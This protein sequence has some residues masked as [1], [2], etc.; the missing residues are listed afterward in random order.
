M[1]AD[2][3]E[4]AFARLMQLGLERMPAI[5]LFRRCQSNLEKALA[6]AEHEAPTKARHKAAGEAAKEKARLRREIATRA[7]SV[8]GRGIVVGIET[9]T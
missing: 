3:E 1:W 7:V 5:R 6:I 2:A 8:S 9:V 4:R